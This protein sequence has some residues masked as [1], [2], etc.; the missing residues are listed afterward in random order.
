MLLRIGW[1]V[2]M[3]S[4]AVPGV[5]GQDRASVPN[6]R[7]GA[8]FSSNDRR[9]AIEPT[10]WPWRAIGRVNIAD[11]V[12]RRYCTGTLV[13]PQLAVTAAHC[14]FDGRLGHWVKPKHVHFVVG[15]AR[16]TFAGLSEAEDIIVSPEA[17]AVLSDPNNGVL[18][19]EAVA[20]DWALIRLKEA[21]PVKPVP[22]KSITG[23]AF[24]EAVAGGEIARAGYGADRPYL[25]SVH[26]G[27][28]AGISDTVAGLLLNQCDALP[29][30]SGSPILLLRGD[31]AFIIG[32]SSGAAHVRQ[33]DGSYLAIEGF[34]P[35][36]A[37]FA[38]A[39]K[40][41]QTH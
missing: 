15:Q 40:S 38:E 22:V 16:D 32:L 41:A 28:A 7:W 17:R 18:L 23:E 25:L 26:R 35:A 4:A 13:D 3:L 27:C 6:P 37:S 34:G 19:A 14:L 5:S 12:T 30:D 9:V 20:H 21:L 36:A 31:Q 10:I 8:Y 2:I 29:G 33:P 24:A 39:I 11:S 1:F